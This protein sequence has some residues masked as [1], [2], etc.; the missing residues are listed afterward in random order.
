MRYSASGLHLAPRLVRE[1]QHRDP[2]GSRHHRP[3]QGG[4]RAGVQRHET[5]RMALCQADASPCPREEDRLLCA[6]ESGSSI[7]VPVVDGAN[8]RHGGGQVVAGRTGETAIADCSEAPFGQF[9]CSKRS[10]TVC[11][12]TRIFLTRCLQS[13]AASG[14][15]GVE[16]RPAACHRHQRRFRQ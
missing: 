9:L 7:S 16:S 6:R 5:T 1:Q 15:R 13:C 8:G 3:G 12:S 4:K 2:R 10:R 11:P 14:H